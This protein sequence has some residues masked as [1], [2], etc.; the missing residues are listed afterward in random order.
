MMMMI[1][2][3]MVF[4][5]EFRMMPC[6]LVDARTFSIHITDVIPEDGGN[7]LL[8]SVNTCVQNCVASGE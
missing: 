2:L 6:S 3:I 5:L 4:R 8:R 1:I 7:T